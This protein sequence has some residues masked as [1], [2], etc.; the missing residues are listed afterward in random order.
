MVC[1]YRDKVEGDSRLIKLSELKTYPELIALG[2]IGQLM[3]K[4]VLDRFLKDSTT[5]EEKIKK[6]LDWLDSFLGVE[7]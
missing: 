6:N 1:C 4:G 5:K 3:T 2:S 7:K